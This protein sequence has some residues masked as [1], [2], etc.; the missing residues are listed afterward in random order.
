MV[1]D[2]PPDH[3][4][5]D[6]GDD[7]GDRDRAK[8][9]P[10]PAPGEKHRQRVEDEHGD[11]HEDAQ[12]AQPLGA[13]LNRLELVGLHDHDLARVRRQLRRQAEPLLEPPQK[14][15][16]I[17]HDVLA[18]DRDPLRVALDDRDQPLVHLPVR[19]LPDLL[20]AGP[21]QKLVGGADGQLL[22][23]SCQ[24]RG[25][26]LSVLGQA[27]LEGGRDVDVVIEFVD[28]EDRE[29]APNLVVLQQARARVHPRVRLERLPL[30]P[31]RQRAHD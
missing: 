5:D 4:Q 23:T 8:C 17:E 10:A 18:L 3:E 15:P 12:R 19:R 1:L 2:E 31:H 30:R 29:G 24:G 22:E 28:E 11:D 6:A 21:L 25:E 13:G 9:L 14:R 20:Q 26:P 16:Q 7:E 27:L